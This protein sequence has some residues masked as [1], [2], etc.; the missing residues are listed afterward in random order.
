MATIKFIRR[1]R[2]ELI[3][4]NQ[5]ENSSTIAFDV[6]SY[7]PL[8]FCHLSP[9]TY[10]TQFNIPVS[11]MD[12]IY[13]HSVE[14][15]WQ[16]LKV[17]DGKIDESFFVKKPKKRQGNVQ[18]YLFKQRLL[19]AQDAREKIY[20]PAY[21][22]YLDNCAP[23]QAIETIL[24]K[25]REGKEIFLY[26]TANNGDLQDLQPYAHAAVLATYLNFQRKHRQFAP[27]NESE[28]FL[29]QILTRHETLEE[30]AAMIRQ[31]LFDLQFRKAFEYRCVE[32]PPSI[33]EYHIAEALKPDLAVHSTSQ[34]TKQKQQ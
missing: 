28:W 6:S 26:D 10:D 8:P 7:A 9:L 25:Q 14:G 29:E 33:D 1:A 27:T 21:N 3:S 19:C 11:G 2:G 18:G 15:I 4:R 32:H 5:N 22:F 13:A 17:I 20:I 23:Q 12:A 30:K 24:T 31:R 34:K 16:G